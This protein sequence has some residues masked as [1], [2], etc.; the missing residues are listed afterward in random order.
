MGEDKRET[1]LFFMGR[2][3]V[4]DSLNEFG[5]NVSYVDAFIFRR[6]QD[7]NPCC[8]LR[9]GE[10]RWNRKKEADNYKGIFMKNVREKASPFSGYASSR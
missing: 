7:M 4:V 8:E 6:K 10:C 3:Q 5:P 9:S 1:S 2:F